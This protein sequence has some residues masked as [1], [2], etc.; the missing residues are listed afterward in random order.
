[1][2]AYATYYQHVAGQFAITTAAGN[3]MYGRAA[4]FVD[5]SRLSMPSY[6]RPLCPAEPLGSRH[7]PDFYAHDAK[8]PQG[9]VHAPPGMTNAQVIGDFTHR[10]I[11]QQ[12]GRFTLAVAGDFVKLFSWTHTASA[13]PDAPTFRWQFQTYYPLWEPTIT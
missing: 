7:S 2:L 4:S 6:E 3:S 8:S 5:C 13:N 9:N 1:M 12:P 11:T 10:A